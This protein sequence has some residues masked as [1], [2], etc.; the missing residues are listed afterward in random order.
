MDTRPVASKT[1]T[2]RDAF[3]QPITNKS[4]GKELEQD[5][6]EKFLLS[7][8]RIKISEDYYHLLEDQ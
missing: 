8:P 4:S 5:I 6:C 1:M 3:Q 2:T 7:K